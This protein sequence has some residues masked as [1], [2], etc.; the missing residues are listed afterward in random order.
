MKKEQILFWAI[1]LFITLFSVIFQRITGP[2]YPISGKFKI[3]NKTVSFKLARSHAGFTD[4]KISIPAPTANINARLE[5]K[6]YKVNEE[7]RAIDFVRNDTGDSLIAFLPKQPPA[8]KLQYRIIVKSSNEAQIIPEQPIII[9]FRGE[10][11]KTILILHVVFI[12]MAL[13]FSNRAGLEFFNNINPK[14]ELYSYTTLICLFLG[15]LIFGPIMQKYAFG[16]YWTGFPFGMDLTDNKTIF[17]FIFWIIVLFSIK[18]NA[19]A[20]YYVLFA[21]IITFIIFLIPHSLL[22]SELDYSKIDSLK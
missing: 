22:G 14:F 2:T 19:K 12:F 11:P 6:R 8:G 16:E 17:A 4:H 21:S 3:D 10:V 7:W 18:N 1:S 15:G 13:L 5:W 9:R 20:K